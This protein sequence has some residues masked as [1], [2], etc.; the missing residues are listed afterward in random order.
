MVEK[1][2]TLAP[3]ADVLAVADMLEIVAAELRES[4]STLHHQAA[5]VIAIHG[6]QHTDTRI[7]FAG[8]VRNIAE[9]VGLLELGKMQALMSDG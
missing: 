1:I 7:H 3:A 5:L 9:G 6:K 4:G 2:V 8:G